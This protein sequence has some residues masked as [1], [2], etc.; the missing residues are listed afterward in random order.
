MSQRNCKKDCHKK[1]AAKKTATKD[2]HK[3]IATKK[4]AT[5]DCHKKMPQKDCHKKDCQKMPQRRRKIV[6]TAQQIAQG[7]ATRIKYE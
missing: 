7:T 4:I 5:K 2:C 1:I 6:M 3:K